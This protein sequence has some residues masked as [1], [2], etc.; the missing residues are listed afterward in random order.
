MGEAGTTTTGIAGCVPLSADP[1]CA[2]GANADSLNTIR[3]RWRKKLGDTS[4][5]VRTQANGN[6]IRESILMGPNGGVKLET[7][8]DGTKL[9]TGKPLGGR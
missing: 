9:I 7:V 8:W 4:N 2:G 6:V 5:T 1:T 3:E